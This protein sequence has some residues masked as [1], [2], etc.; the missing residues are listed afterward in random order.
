MAVKSPWR[1]RLSA[2]LWMLGGSGLVFLTI[3]YMNGMQEAPKKQEV[4]QQTRFQVKPPPPKPP[5]KKVEK[6]QVKQTRKSS[7][8]PP[9]PL[10]ELSQGLSGLDLGLPSYQ[11]QDVGQVDQTILGN[12]DNVVMTSDTVDIPPRAKQRPALEYPAR[13]KAK[14]IEGYVVLSILISTDGKVD[15]Y[16]VLE[17]EPSGVFED[18]AIKNIQRWL[19]EPARYDGKAVETWATQTIRFEL[20]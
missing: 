13:A 15:S 14:E 1:A 20:G 2:L 16:K 8:P 19:F 7:A 10:A 9:A 17:A 3:I 12:T 5:K 11:I 6:K 18:T 4:S